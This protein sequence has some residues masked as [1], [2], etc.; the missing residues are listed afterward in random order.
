MAPEERVPI[1]HLNRASLAELDDLPGIGPVLARA[2]LHYRAVHGSFESAEELTLI[3][4]IGARK[5]ARLRGRV[6]P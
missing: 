1:V 4:G 6:A 5:W 3:P 2:I